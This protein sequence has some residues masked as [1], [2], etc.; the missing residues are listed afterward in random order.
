MIGC[1]SVAWDLYNRWRRI[2]RRSALIAEA[3]KELVKLFTQIALLRRGPQD[4]PASMLLLALTIVAYLAMNL[5]LNSLLPPA[6]PA[7]AAARVAEADQPNWSAQL[8]LDTLF[9]LLWYVALLRLAGRPERTLQTST[10]V[11][12]IQIV[13]APLLFLS[14]WLSPRFPHDSP[15]FVPVAL[16]GI[17]LFVWFVAANG[18]IV[19]AALEWSL[20]PSVAL[21]LLQILAGE[22]LQRAL[23]PITQG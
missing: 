18:H 20:G 13:L 2:M 8:L 12:G 16:F 10:A 7:D 9:T 4:L 6:A 15:W 11:L 3:M 5:L 21:V 1:K 23:F 19:K 22:L 14:R 17:V